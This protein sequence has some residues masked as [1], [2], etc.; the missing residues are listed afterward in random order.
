MRVKTVQINW[1]DRLPI[2]SVDFDHSWQGDGWRFSTGGG[3]NNVRIWR[4]RSPQDPLHEA[5][6]V[7]FLASLNRHT[8]PVNV[9]RFSPASGRLASAGDDGV[10]I[11]WR[12][13]DSPP[14]ALA[15]HLED[16]AGK[17]T[18]RPAAMLRGSLA[19]ICDLA[20]SPD[21][22]FLV[23]ASVDNTARVWD[24]REA[25]CVQVLADHSHYVQGVAWDPLNEFVATQSSDRSLRIYR[26]LGSR[27]RRAGEQVARLE[28]SHRSMPA[29]DGRS[30][31]Q[32]LFHDDNLASFFRRPSVSPDGRLLATA[33][34]VQRQPADARN[35]CFI[36]ARDR[37][38]AEP[39][40][41]LAGH[42]KP[43]VATRWAPCMFAEAGAGAGAGWLSQGPRMM[44]AVAS[45]S[46]VSLY[47]TSV[48][49]RAVG[50]M[51]GL[52]YAA[53]ADL[54]WAADGSHLVIVSID[55][56]AS[57]ASLDQPTAALPLPLPLHDPVPEAQPASR[58]AANPAAH[59]S[60]ARKR[61][62]PTLVS[63]L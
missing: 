58:P 40:L 17:E 20:W 29:A 63:T 21:G 19:D 10:I 54:A 48:G 3:D 51:D 56:F 44:L 41:R 18:W 27:S 43:I 26:W 9:V 33:A 45:Q 31:R 59:K 23:S 4:L 8:A 50:L 30:H 13:V 34:G 55:G 49:A 42:A 2:F 36:W 32:R 60:Q 52:H 5:Q 38:R 22:A 11:I 14:A 24:A 57:V 7:E 39:V 12:Q 28:A 46:A 47:D 61:V 16:S 25:R 15:D 1:H 6:P 37:L 53:I 35:A 62:A